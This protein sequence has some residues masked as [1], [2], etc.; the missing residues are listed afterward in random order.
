[1]Q[2]VGRRCLRSGPGA[3]ARV[4]AE[5]CLLGFGIGVGIKDTGSG[6]R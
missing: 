1:M 6:T 3:V 5:G 2:H 4:R